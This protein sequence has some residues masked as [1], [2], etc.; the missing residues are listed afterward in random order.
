MTYHADQ[1]WTAVVNPDVGAEVARLRND[2]TFRARFEAKVDRRTAGE[3]ECH[4]WTAAMSSE[5]YGNFTVGKRTVRAH[6]VA[7]ILRFG[8]VT[9]D[10]YLDHVWPVCRYRFCVNTDHLEPVDHAENVRRG[11]GIGRAAQRAMRSHALAARDVW[12]RTA[13]GLLIPAAA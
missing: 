4:I 1:R 13:A 10:L 5:G 7:Y 8:A 11:V 3:D 12:E 2:D 9:G 6:L